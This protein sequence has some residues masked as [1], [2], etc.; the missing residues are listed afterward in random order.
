LNNYKT[1]FSLDKSSKIA[2]T[3]FALKNYSD[4]NLFVKNKMGGGRQYC[5]LNKTNTIVSE[6]AKNIRVS[7]FKNIGIDVFEE[8]PTYG[9]LL[10]VITENSFVHRHIDL[11]KPGFHHFRLNFLVSKPE[12]G[13][14]PI[15]NGET[16]NVSEGESWVNVASVWNH[17]ST[18]V[19]GKKPRIVLSLGGLVEYH[20]IDNI[21]KEMG[22]E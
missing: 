16:F 9:I 2:L 15:I 7:M 4:R 11:T 14:M 19:V 12:D 8:E 18:Q 5:I 13:G 3:N 20:I 21:M 6:L 17:S 22:I 1:K 10:G